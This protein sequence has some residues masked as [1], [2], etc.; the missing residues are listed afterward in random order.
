ME[1]IRVLEEER[2]KERHEGVSDSNVGSSRGIDEERISKLREEWEAEKARE[3]REINHERRK[4]QV[5][6]NEMQANA[7]R[8][9]STRL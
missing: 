9:A 1:K 4:S 8:E 6:D 7:I 5:A 2:E 3:I